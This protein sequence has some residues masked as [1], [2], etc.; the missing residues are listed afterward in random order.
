MEWKNKLQWYNSNARESLVREQCS[1]SAMKHFT[2]GFSISS[3][4]SFLSSPARIP[5]LSEI[6]VRVRASKRTSV[7]LSNRCPNG[8]HSFVWTLRRQVGL[9]KKYYGF[10][11]LSG[12]SGVL[13]TWRGWNG[14]LVIWHMT[15]V[16][17]LFSCLTAQLFCVLI[18]QYLRL[19][20]HTERMA[21]LVSNQQKRIVLE[22][23]TWMIGTIKH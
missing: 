5:F 10:W 2:L 11:S 15:L 14:W 12:E 3:H 20:L 9:A 19:W 8:W 16:K 4:L 18:Q 17:W 7:V 6:L 1:N 21:R 22:N 13:S 23:W